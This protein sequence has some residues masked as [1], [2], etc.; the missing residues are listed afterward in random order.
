M[1]V[2][3]G[4]AA[5]EADAFLCSLAWPFCYWLRLAHFAAAMTTFFTMTEKG[6]GERE[7]FP[8]LHP[9]HP[10]IVSGKQAAILE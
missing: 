1:L 10:K 7:R 9:F 4:V 2:V 8:I 3:F 6:F 5:L